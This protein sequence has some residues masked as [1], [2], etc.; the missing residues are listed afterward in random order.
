MKAQIDVE[1][2]PFS[3]PNFARVAGKNLDQNRDDSAAVALSTLDALTLE[4]LCD[5]FRAEV[6]RKAGKQRPPQPARYCP[7]C[8]RPV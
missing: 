4:R 6:F 2:E 3:T 8:E 5:D 1:I 7:K